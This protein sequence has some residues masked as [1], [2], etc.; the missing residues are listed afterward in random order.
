MSYS[1]V[2]ASDQL[3]HDAYAQFAVDW[4]WG[5]ADRWSRS[6]KEGSGT[7]WMCVSG[8]DEEAYRAL[9]AHFGLTEWQ[10]EFPMSRIITMSPAELAHERRKKE[11]VHCLQSKEIRSDTLGDH[12]APAELPKQQLPLCLLEDE[13]TDGDGMDPRTLYLT[14]STR[15]EGD[16]VERRRISLLPDEARRLVEISDD[17]HL[18]AALYARFGITDLSPKPGYPAGPYYQRCGVSLRAELLKWLSDAA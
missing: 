4:E 10:N 6:E 7:A 17:D 8:L 12:S 13:R 15:A 3:G 2:Y 1:V 18:T 5:D 9:L 16:W 14:I 11:K